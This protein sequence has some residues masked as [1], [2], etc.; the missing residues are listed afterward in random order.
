MKDSTKITKSLTLKKKHT[1]LQNHS[2]DT[3][4]Q[5]GPLTQLSENSEK[6]Q[7]VPAELAGAKAQ[8][9]GTKI[10]EIAEAQMADELDSDTSLLE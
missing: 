4:D 1:Q 7:N 2:L 6:E 9:C 5:V 3:I 8:F 10:E